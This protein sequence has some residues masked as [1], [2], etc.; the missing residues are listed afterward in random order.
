M[1]AVPHDVEMLIASTVG[2]DLQ[3]W[4]AAFATER[5]FD[6]AAYRAAGRAVKPTPA[7]RSAIQKAVRDALRP[8]ADDIRSLGN[9]RF[10]AATGLTET[11]AAAMMKRATLSDEEYDYA[12]TPLIAAGVPRSIFY[13]EDAS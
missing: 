5:S 6:R 12:A 9:G 2:L 8:R 1:A 7:E 3:S 4:K 13:G 10:M 11:A